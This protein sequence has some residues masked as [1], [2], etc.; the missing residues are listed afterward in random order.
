MQPTHSLRCN[1]TPQGP[2][3]IFLPDHT[4]LQT[5]HQHDSLM[6]KSH[7]GV[8]LGLLV[9]T[10]TAVSIVLF[11]YYNDKIGDVDTAV[12]AYMVSDIILLSIMLLAV[13]WGELILQC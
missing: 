4:A 11:F 3:S 8:F 7:T 13:I 12:L 1:L 10:G 2:F 6:T 5:H 9:L